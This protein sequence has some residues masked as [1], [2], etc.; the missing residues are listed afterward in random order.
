MDIYGHIMPET[1]E[2]SV[3]VLDN[4]FKKDK[5]DEPRLNYAIN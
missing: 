4:I 1:A 3:K 5:I 2:Q